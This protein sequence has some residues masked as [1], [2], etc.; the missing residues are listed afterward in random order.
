MMNVSVAYAAVRQAADT[1]CEWIDASTTELF[2][3]QA[4]T[5]AQATD[6]FVPHWA[7]GNPVLRISRVAVIELDTLEDADLK[8]RLLRAIGG[9]E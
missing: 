3:I 9:E 2:P 8:H 6:D 5:K 1:A 4:E 7:V